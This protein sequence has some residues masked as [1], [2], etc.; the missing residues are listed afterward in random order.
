MFMQPYISTASTC[1]TAKKK[2][3]PFTFTKRLLPNVNKLYV[4]SNYAIY[5]FSGV[6]SSMEKSL[7]LCKRRSA[8]STCAAE[9]SALFSS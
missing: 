1:I 9:P 2:Q 4:L 6:T 3:S 8:P 7:K 5:L